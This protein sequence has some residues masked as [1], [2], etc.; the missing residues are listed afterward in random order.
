MDGE[1]RRWRWTLIPI[2]I[3]YN[4]NHV[5]SLSRVHTFGLE[6]VGTVATYELVIMDIHSEVGQAAGGDTGIVC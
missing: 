1:R 2:W 6:M 5:F 3:T 4:N